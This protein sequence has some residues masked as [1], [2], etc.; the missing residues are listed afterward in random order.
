[1]IK[2]FQRLLGSGLIIGSLSLSCYA[3]QEFDN[4][5]FERYLSKNAI[6][7]YESADPDQQS[8]IRNRLRKSMK[9]TLRDC[10]RRWEKGGFGSPDELYTAQGVVSSILRKGSVELGDSGHYM[11]D[12][13][14]G[15]YDEYRHKLILG[16]LSD[17]LVL[18]AQNVLA[19]TAPG[20]AISPYSAPDVLKYKE[21]HK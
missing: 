8:M 16:I 3:A 11:V 14:Y 1:M 2:N 6:Q 12:P 21:T 5:E 20:I 9:D 19:E 18:T 10:G 4:Q 17:Q 15:S 13:S 7:Y